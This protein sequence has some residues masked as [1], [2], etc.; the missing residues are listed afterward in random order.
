MISVTINGSETEL[1]GPT[2][3]RTLISNPKTS[4]SARSRSQLTA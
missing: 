4:Q 1:D 3:L 2:G